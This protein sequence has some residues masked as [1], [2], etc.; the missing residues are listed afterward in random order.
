[1][2]EDHKDRLGNKL[3]DVEKAREDQWARQSDE[4]LLEKM[5][6]RLH[7][8]RVSAMQAVPRAEDRE[9]GAP[10]RLPGRPWRVARRADIEDAAEGAQVS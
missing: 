1:M 10:A 2:A 6:E 4:K 7:Q 5:R 3:H 9:R 8:A